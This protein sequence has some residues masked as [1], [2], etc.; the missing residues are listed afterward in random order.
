MTT[1]RIAAGSGA[2]AVLLSAG[3]AGAG[4]SAA[5]PALGA[6]AW[7]PPWDLGL[8]WS[9]VTVTV[10]LVAADVLGAAA[11]GLGLLAVYRGAR[12][13]PRA[14]A[15]AALAAVALLAVV[16][17]LG[18]AD[19]LSYAAY[20][21][22]AAQGDDPYVED[23]LG[24]RAGTDPVAGAVQEPWEHTPSVYGPVGTLAQTVAAGLGDGSLR[25]TVWLWQL[26][27]AAAF[28]AAA[29]ILDR[30]TRH[31]PAAR[32]RAA[33]IWTL[34]PLLLRQLVLGGHIDV[35]AVAAALGAV[36][37][38]ARRPLLA[39]M[40]LGAAAG[41][42]APYALAGLAICWG[43][44]RLP[45]RDALRHTGLGLLGAALVLVPAH[46]W[47]GPHTY[48]QLGTAS[49]MISLATPW[50]L[51]AD[52]LDPAFGRPLVR[53]V[54][55]VAAVLTAA[56]LAVLLARRL[57]AVPT[58]GE[59]PAAA[60]GPD[61][62]TP[63]AVRAAVVLFGAWVLTTPYALPWYDAMVW[64]PLALLTLRGRDRWL[65]A[66]LLARLAALSLAYVP[67]RVVALTPQV[68]R[69]TLAF[70]REVVPWLTLAA[71]IAVVWWAFAREPAPPRGEPRR[72]V[73]AP[74]R[75]PR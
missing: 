13:R 10:L 2:L 27:A 28:L 39:G 54:V 30:L 19:H 6:A 11:V 24:W 22:I 29:W 33:V 21:R 57:R 40:L 47:S 74:E 75:S 52:A 7:H 61:L 64:A 38:A 70:R 45:R 56:V 36:A 72:P 34:N 4:E 20:G 67:G 3:V 66:A 46:L 35:I 23:P 48:D 14:V 59:G 18:S 17:P 37:L 71:V 26:L 55:R 53:S 16:P 8:G 49:R 9:P 50:R 5:V 62:V 44:R 31:D 68:E 25:L 63:D 43:L 41:T 60:E 32:A 15:S 73:P 51:L 42:K 12:P 65:D 69:V 1:G 58:A